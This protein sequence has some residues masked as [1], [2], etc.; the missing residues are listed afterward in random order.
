MTL[1]GLVAEAWAAID[2]RK[3]G[4]GNISLADGVKHPDHATHRS[5]LE[6]DVR[7][8]RKDGRRLPCSIHDAQYD[9]EATTKLIALF[10]KNAALKVV[11]FNDLAIPH[12]TPAKGH[13]DHFHIQ[14][15]GAK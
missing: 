7:P 13:H 8:V 6:V 5:G 11:L 14:L 10:R 12:V 2:E 4:V 1:I 3:F 15:L 9:R